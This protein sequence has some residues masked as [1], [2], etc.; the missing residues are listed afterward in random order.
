MVDASLRGILT[1][2]KTIG[3]PWINW[4][5]GSQLLPMVYWLSSNKENNEGV[6]KVD[7]YTAISAQL[8]ALN[9]SIDAIQLQQS[10]NCGFYR[11]NHP[12]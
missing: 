8:V 1:K 5:D 10:M 3:S 7:P 11:S 2:K 12:N 9:I 6:Q 4:G